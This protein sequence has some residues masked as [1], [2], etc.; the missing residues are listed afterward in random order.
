VPVVSQ[1]PSVQMV[2]SYAPTVVSQKAPV[3]TIQLPVIPTISPEVEE[4]VVET[5]PQPIVSQD[6]DE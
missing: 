5:F 4:T 1:A 6:V 3:Q 2:P